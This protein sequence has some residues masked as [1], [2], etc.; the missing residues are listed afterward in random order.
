MDMFKVSFALVIQIKEIKF[1]SI[2]C[3]ICSL[4]EKSVGE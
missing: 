3:G 4:Q 2:L 1:A